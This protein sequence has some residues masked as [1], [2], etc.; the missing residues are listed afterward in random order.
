MAHRILAIN[1]GSTS[2]KIAVYDDLDPIFTLTI[3]HTPEDLAPFG[4]LSEQFAWRKQLIEEALESKN[5]DL[6][7]IDAVIGRGGIICPVESGVYEVN[8]ALRNDLINAHMQHASNLGGLIAR[9]LADEIG[10][11][12]YI[13]DPVVVD[14]MIPYARLSGIPELPR[15]SIFHALNQKAI[16]R[17]YARESGH[18]YEK[19]N[20]IVCHMGGGITVSAH[21]KGRVIDTTNALD[22][23]GP[24]SPERSGS[25]PPGP[26]VRLCFSGKYTEEELIKMVHG[27]GGMMAHLGITSVPDVLER[28]DNGDLHATLVLRAMIYSVC[29]EIGAMAA[30]LKGDIDAILL[31]G[32]MAHSRRI[33]D[34]MAEHIS[35]IAPIF[36]YPGEDELKSLAENALAVINGEQQVKE[37]RSEG[38]EDP[39]RINDR[40][41][42]SKLRDILQAAIAPGISADGP[43]SAIRKYLRRWTTNH[44]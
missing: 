32:G 16:A 27:K 9:D 23:C 5:I 30:A 25:L 42:P 36:V 43:M 14:E 18:P 15:Q 11:K 10:V 7:S 6:R 33:T 17:R 19:L 35:F 1:P 26:L 37:Y 40:S 13:A 12:S 2:T 3:H 8:D 39:A 38:P 34:F 22:G 28:V 44:K 24:F 29:K 4:H 41:L 21:R 31:T 20:L